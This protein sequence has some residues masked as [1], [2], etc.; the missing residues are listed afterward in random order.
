MNDTTFDRGERPTRPA[1]LQTP[2][3]TPA[4]DRGPTVARGADGSDA[5]GVEADF[6]IGNLLKTAAD[7]FL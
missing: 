3:Q 6:G 2:F 7:I 1:A 5:D 4:I